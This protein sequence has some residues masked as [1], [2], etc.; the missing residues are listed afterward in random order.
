MTTPAA[1][2]TL[3]PSNASDAG[4]DPGHGAGAPLTIAHVA[5]PAAVGGLESA[6]LLLASAQARAGH[7]VHVLPTLLRPDAAAPWVERLRG[8]GVE[9]TPILGRG[10][11]YLGEVRRLAE[12]FERLRPAIVHT[13]GYRS[14]ILGLLAARRAG[15]PTVTTL[16][17]FVGGDR[18]ARLYEWVQRRAVRRFDAVIAVSASMA[19]AL[20]SRGLRSDRLH[21]VPNAFASLEEPLSRADARR[22]LDV[23]PDGFRAGWI[24]RL[25]P[26]KGV[27]VA[28]AALA[29]E[30]LA[31]AELSVIGDGAEG[32]AARALAERLGVAGRVTWH[33]AMAGAAR[34]V[35]AFDVLV[36][37]SRT[38]GT[39]ITIFEAMAAGVPIVAT[40]V[41]GVPDVLRDAEARLVAPERPDELA[42][43][44]ADVH[45]NP[46]AAARRAAAARARLDTHYALGPWVERHLAIYR[47]VARQATG[48]AAPRS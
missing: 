3:P 9:V 12:R 6:L 25:S 48:A 20:T 46:A 23:P 28:V 42:A 29:D 2:S 24:G 32:A 43:A 17:G 1:L 13:H 34:F 11:N 7:R 27:D 26:E 22:A 38:E 40:R 36:L 41:G 8:A 33:G 35:R 18:K 5:T 4:G 10:R 14:D 21:V 19:G 16:H 39:P 31:G 45:A 15:V 37:S 44:I 47:A 30:T